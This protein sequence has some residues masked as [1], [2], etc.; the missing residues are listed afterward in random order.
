M[1]DDLI[2]NQPKVLKQIVIS[3]IEIGEGVTSTNVQWR[4][5]DEITAYGLLEQ[6]RQLIQVEFFKQ[7]VANAP[8]VQPANGIPEGIRR[9]LRG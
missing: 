2:A 8:R 7:K 3:L 4:D 9:H 5:V 1:A 6:A